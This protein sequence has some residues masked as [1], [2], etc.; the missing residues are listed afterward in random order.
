MKTLLKIFLPLLTIAGIICI[1]YPPKFLTTT[2][3]DT[4]LPCSTHVD[5]KIAVLRYGVGTKRFDDSA[6]YRDIERLIRDCKDNHRFNK[7]IPGKNKD[8]S[9]TLM[10]RLLDVYRDKFLDHARNIYRDST[11]KIND[12]N[13]IRSE[14]KEIGVV[15]DTITTIVKYYDGIDSLIKRCRSFSPKPGGNFSMDSVKAKIVSAKN[16]QAAISKLESKKLYLCE[17]KDTLDR[18]SQILFDRHV[19]FLNGKTDILLKKYMEEYDDSLLTAA[20]DEVDVLNKNRGIYIN[21]GVD[22]DTIM[23][24][25]ETLQEKL[26]EVR[27]KTRRYAEYR[28]EIIE[29]LQGTVLDEV[30][31][32]EYRDNTAKYGTTK[33]LAASINLCLEFWALDGSKGK[34]YSDL[35]SK[36]RKDDNLNDSKLKSALE[37]YLIGKTTY[38]Y[39]TEKRMELNRE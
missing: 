35:L 5:N 27:V 6:S 30:K 25:Y 28:E 18:I 3:D 9:D 34:K 38:N 32:K 14:Y 31:L 36:V 13:Y 10:G 2:S 33:K 8:C 16:Y 12:L 19:N 7:D 23:K 24:R 4:S 37:K 15:N 21:N 17:C 26:N 29:Y 11:C 20:E 1:I 39:I 22:A